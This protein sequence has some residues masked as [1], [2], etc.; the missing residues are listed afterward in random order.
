MPTY[1][2]YGVGYDGYFNDNPNWFAG[3]SGGLEI[4]NNFTRYTYEETPEED[5]GL[6]TGGVSLQFTGY[7]TSSATGLHTFELGS[8]DAG[9][10]W[11]G[12][13]AESGFTVNNALIALPGTHGYYTSTATIS[14]TQ[15]TPYFIRLQV[16]NQAAGFYNPGELSLGYA[17]PGQG[18]FTYDA[19][20]SNVYTVQQP[21]T[22]TPTPTNT[23]APTL[24]PTPTPTGTG[25]PTPT[26]TITPTPE[27]PQGFFTRRNNQITSYDSLTALFAV[28]GGSRTKASTTGLSSNYV[29]LADLFD[30]ALYPGEK[31]NFNTGFS[32]NGV[33][34]KEIFRADG[35]LVTPT[36]T[37]SPT[38]TGTPPPTSTPSP[39]TPPTPVPTLPPP[40]TQAP[41][42]ASPYVSLTIQGTPSLGAT[43][44]FNTIGY[45]N[46]NGNITRHIVWERSGSEPNQLGVWVANYT[47]SPNTTTSTLLNV[48]SFTF[49]F[50]GYYQFM[51][52]IYLNNGVLGYSSTPQFVQIT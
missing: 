13:T 25:T 44:S 7:F 51:A 39:T 40:P 37:P 9:Y 35:I 42:P 10:L 12:S 48:G 20:Q 11:V 52:A 15:N 50:V 32:V 27:P 22:P 1:G 30:P 14:L 23:G 24:T 33:D 46:G 34:L 26:P 18:S 17:L 19:S 38:P 36:P 28:Y 45:S 47:A 3:R 41:P 4:R 6:E 29:D 43:V 21:T 8:D 5:S 16:G 2:L 49:A 31:I